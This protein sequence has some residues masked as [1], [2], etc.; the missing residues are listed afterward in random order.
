MTQKEWATTYM[1]IVID[2][3]IITKQVQQLGNLNLQDC[4][5]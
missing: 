3:I 5:Q 2:Q 1:R 4:A